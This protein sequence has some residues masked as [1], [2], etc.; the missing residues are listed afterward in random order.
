MSAD[1]IVQRYVSNLAQIE[2]TQLRQGKILAHEWTKVAKAT[3]TLSQIRVLIDDTPCP[4]VEQIRSKVRATISQYKGLRLVVIDYSLLIVDG[5]DSRL[6]QRL[7]EIT[8]QLKLLRVSV[9][10]RSCCCRS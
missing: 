1:A 10:C 2:A 3:D 5:G 9:K 6:V 7:G 8:R 4:S